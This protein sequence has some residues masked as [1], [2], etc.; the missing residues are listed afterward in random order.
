MKMHRPAL[1]HAEM[2]SPIPDLDPHANTK[3]YLAVQ[4]VMEAVLPL[5]ARMRTPALLLPG[6]MQAVVKAQCALC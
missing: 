6:P 3:L 5:L 1:A 4:D 2:C